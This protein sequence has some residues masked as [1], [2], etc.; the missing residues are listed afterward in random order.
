MGCELSSTRVIF[1]YRDAHSSSQPFNA[2]YVWFN[3]SDNEVIADPTISF[4]NSYTGGVTQQATS[5][6]TQTNQLCYEGNG[7][8]Y[9]I[10]GFEYR[11]GFDNAVSPTLHDFTILG[12]RSYYSVYYLGF[13]QQGFVDA[14]RSGYGSRHSRRNRR[15]TGPSRTDVHHCEPGHVVQFRRRRSRAHTLPGTH[16]CRLHPCVPKSRREEHRV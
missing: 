4:Q 5:V 11:P 8:C 3:T 9:S 14:Q 1:T 13:R 7:G 10:Y 2:A 16:V 6:V 15:K 12:S